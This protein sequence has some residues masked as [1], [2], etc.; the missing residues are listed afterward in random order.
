MIYETAGGE[1]F[2]LS[3]LAPVT[4]HWFDGTVRRLVPVA[5]SRCGCRFLFRNLNGEIRVVGS[6]QGDRMEQWG[7]YI[8]VLPRELPP[9]TGSV[10][11]PLGRFVGV[12][13]IRTEQGTAWF[14]P[15]VGI[16]KTTDFVLVDVKE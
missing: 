11:T 1:R 10:Q 9:R 6:I 7:E 2:S 8:Q 3:F 4:A 16:V 5:D 15:G 14:A 12:V 13:E